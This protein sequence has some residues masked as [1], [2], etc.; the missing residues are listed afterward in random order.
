MFN[1]PNKPTPR[2]SSLINYHIAGNLCWL[3]IFM[4]FTDRPA[5]AKIKLQTKW[6]K[7]EIDDVIMCVH[8]YEL[9]PVWTSWFSMVCL[10]CK[11]SLYSRISLPLHK[12]QWTCKRCSKSAVLNS[13]EP[14][15]LPM[16]ATLILCKGL[17]TKGRLGHW[18]TSLLLCFVVWFV[19]EVWPSTGRGVVR[20]SCICFREYMMMD[21]FPQNFA[22]AKISHYTVFAT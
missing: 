9:V 3:Q 7:M 22:P 14:V 18:C 2:A 21:V 20:T 12:Y 19:C 15:F 17:H 4:I 6:T 16:A 11:W 10:P 5:S 1:I 8:W 13:S